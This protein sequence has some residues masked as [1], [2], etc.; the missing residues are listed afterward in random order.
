[1][2]RLE[3]NHWFRHEMM[4]QLSESGDALLM[5]SW[6]VVFLVK[7]FIAVSH[8]MASLIGVFLVAR[9]MHELTDSFTLRDADRQKM[10]NGVGFRLLSSFIWL[11]ECSKSWL[12]AQ[13]R[14]CQQLALRKEAGGQF[15]HKKEAA[16]ST[17]KKGK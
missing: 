4:R 3:V 11:C 13:R 9:D 6:T 2:N 12:L 5:V 16:W 15:G 7:T 8:F 17:S 1:M 10:R 14:S